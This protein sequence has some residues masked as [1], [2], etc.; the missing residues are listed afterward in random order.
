MQSPDSDHHEK[1]AKDDMPKVLKIRDTVMECMTNPFASTVVAEK[2]VNI[3]K[4]EISTSS[5]VVDSKQLGLDVIAHA[6][7]TDAEKIISPKIL[8]FAGQQKQTKKR[9]DSD[10]LSLSQLE[11]MKLL[12]Q[13]DSKNKELVQKISKI[14]LPKPYTAL[15]LLQNFGCHSN[16]LAFSLPMLDKVLGG[17]LLPATL[18]EICGPS[19]SGKTQFCILLSVVACLPKDLGGHDTKVLYI[20]TECAFSPQRMCEISQNKYPSYFKNEE[21]IQELLKKVFVKRP[22][23][24][25]SLDLLIK[26]LESEIIEHGIG[27]VIIDS[28]ASLIRKEFGGG[29]N[30]ER[31][32]ILAS[33]A[34]HLK[35]LANNFSIP[36]ST[37]S[38]Y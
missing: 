3:A 11:M 21:K 24:S 37:T 19:G 12:G 26:N 23:D 8:T 16:F 38:R 30:M 32:D 31:T 10:L 2:L 35:C 4:R 14:C 27:L 13:H 9:Q 28:I 18:S 22:S 15:Q 20:D 34:A 5:D 7:S 6:R 1:L 36:V 17:G 29:D 33:Q 25:N